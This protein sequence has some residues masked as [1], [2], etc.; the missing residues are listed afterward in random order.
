MAT[1]GWPPG[2]HSNAFT[3]D[4]HSVKYLRRQPAAAGPAAHSADRIVI[5][6]RQAQTAI[7]S[8]P[9]EQSRRAPVVLFELAKHGHG[10]V[11]GLGPRPHGGHE[12]DGVLLV[13]LGGNDGVQALGVSALGRRPQRQQVWP[14]VV[15]E[16]GAGVR[17]PSGPALLELVLAHVRRHVAAGA[18]VAALVHLGPLV[19][20]GDGALDGLAGGIGPAGPRAARKGRFGVRHS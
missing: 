3:T 8:K 2:D 6:T 1:C 7:H 17:E 16:A 13:P 11:G 5:G 9:V 15:A 4:Q 19:G 12:V 20:G 18:L 10:L 14:V